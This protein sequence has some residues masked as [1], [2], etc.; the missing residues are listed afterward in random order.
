MIQLALSIPIA[1]WAAFVAAAVA[2]NLTP[3]SD[4]LFASATGLRGG[5]RAGVVAGIGVGLGSLVHVALAVGGVAALLAAYPPA[6]TALRWAGAGYLL[7]LAWKAWRAPVPGRGQGAPDLWQ[8]LRQGWLTNVLNPKVA[9]FV[10]AFLPQFADP[11]LGS[12]AGQLA[13]FGLTLT[14]TG[15]LITCLYGAL[16]GVLGRRLQQAGRAMNRV[17]AVVFAGL[18]GKLLLN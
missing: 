10:L 7:W 3:G 6:F 12:V 18:A 13:I 15:T 4:V 2:L 8:A 16:A 1:T 11:S 14:V 17:A 5:P 9:I